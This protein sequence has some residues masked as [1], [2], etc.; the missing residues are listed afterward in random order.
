MSEIIKLENVIQTAGNSLRAVNGVSLCVRERERVMVCGGFGSGKSELMYLIAGMDRPNSGTV[1]V[2]NQAVHEMGRGEAAHFRNRHI[3]IVQPGP[4]FMEGLSVAEN[5]S[6]PLIV[7]GVRPDRRRAAVEDLMETLKI[8]HV[9]H[10]HPAQLSTYEARLACIARALITKP[11]ILILNEITAFLSEREAKK[12]IGTIGEIPQSDDYT[13]LC[14]ADETSAA[15]QMSRT[16]QLKNGKI[17]EDS[18]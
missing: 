10:A 4:G 17:Y 6:L 9:A 7:R 2:L 11:R 14:F 5:I 3:G 18:I 13:M 1:F 16:I 15:L 8:R 12:I